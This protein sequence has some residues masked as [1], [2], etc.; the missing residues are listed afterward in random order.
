MR[1][2]WDAMREMA[3]SIS[4]GLYYECLRAGGMSIYMLH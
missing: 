4:Y 1:S 3:I 2:F